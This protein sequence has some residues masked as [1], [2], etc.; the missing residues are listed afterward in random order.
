MKG[1]R[2]FQIIGLVDE[3]LVEE[4]LRPPTRKENIRWFFHNGLKYTMAACLG[5]L[6]LSTSV[7]VIRGG[8]G[9]REE[10]PAATAPAASTPAAS[11]PAAGDPFDSP[12]PSDSEPFLSYAG[13]V[14]PLTTV[15]ETALTAERR[16]TFS[17][18]REGQGRVYDHY[19]LTNPTDQDITTTLLYPVI[20]QLGDFDQLKPRYDQWMCKPLAGRYAGSFQSAY[21]AKK[22]GSHNLNQPS[23]W[24][25][26]AAV[27]ENGD[28]DYAL[29]DAPAL[30]EV[31]TVYEFTDVSGPTD[32]Y[33]A[34]TLG[35]EFTMDTENTQ[36]LTYGING[37]T[38]DED[39]GWRLYD[40]FIPNG[41]RRDTNPKLL[42]VRGTDIGGYTLQGYADGGCD[43]AIEGVTCTVTRTEMTMEK[44]IDRLCRAYLEE[45]ADGYSGILNTDVRT[46]P[47][48]LYKKC[49]KE[50]LTEY[51]VFAQNPTDRYSDGRLD[52]VI[53]EALILERIFY[54]SSPEITIPAGGSLELSVKSD[55]S[56]S[57]D[58]AGSGSDKEGVE[59][60]DFM[61]SLGSFLTFTQ[62]RLGLE[63]YDYGK[64]YQANMEQG[65]CE[66]MLASH[67]LDAYFSGEDTLDLSKEYY[68]FNMK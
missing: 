34:A 64:S 10:T 5:L 62:Q 4:A 3:D 46:L 16:L 42:V 35:I 50:L 67:N 18:D 45:N 60:Y 49:V 33:D 65:F 17:F 20:G 66:S 2:L 47:I 61:T 21:G 40:F 1:E 48:S 8:F 44:L 24:E 39:S 12:P 63:Y 57:F 28:L 7:E 15:E 38:W 55:K 22:N 23:T 32:V 11:A 54:F 37:C 26:Y 25:D 53:T 6:L 52:D 51:G 31:V 9:R 19:V 13:P 30:D 14:L 41:Q 68:Y 43:A 29:A 58:F 59:G 36:I 56:A 27:I